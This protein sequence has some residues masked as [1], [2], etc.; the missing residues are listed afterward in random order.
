MRTQ[1]IL[2]LAALLTASTGSPAAPVEYDT[3]DYHLVV[4]RPFDSWS[5]DTKVMDGE[6]DT[7]A[8]HRGRV[9]YRVSTTTSTV[10]GAGLTL[11]NGPTDDAITTDTIALMKSRGVAV[12]SLGS[13]HWQMGGSTE[14]EPVNYAL[15]RQAQ[16]AIYVALI[17]KQGDPEK[18]PGSMAARRVLGNVLAFAAIGVGMD[19][20]GALGGSMVATTFAGDI[21]QLPI[22]V[23][24]TFVPFDLPELDATG[25]TKLEV[26]PVK[27]N[28]GGSPGQVI[29]AYK[30][31][32]TDAIRHDALVQALASLAG[33]DTSPD[34]IDAARARDLQHRREIWNA[35]ASAGACGTP[36]DAHEEIKK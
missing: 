12:S 11:L 1:T 14:L 28:E 22:G 29:V 35:C 30:A 10:R 13:Y 17:R 2:W 7:I 25:F 34:A 33:S 4:C 27:V 3:A 31:E 5:G 19:K 23:R 21:A 36:N 16:S 20:F 9:S 26:F 8:S 24:Q 15:M 32:P 6:R 18:I